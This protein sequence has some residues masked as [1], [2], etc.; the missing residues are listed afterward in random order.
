MSK[1]N[2]LYICSKANDPKCPKCS[3]S[4]PHRKCMVEGEVC[5]KWGDCYGK[6]GEY[7]F[8]V[9]CITFSEERGDT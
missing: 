1:D 3:H 8:R 4:L 7:L 5:T 2:K 9:R 6:R